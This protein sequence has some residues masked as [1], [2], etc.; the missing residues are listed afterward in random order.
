DGGASTAREA[1]S[2]STPPFVDVTAASQIAYR[3]GYTLPSYIRRDLKGLL[4]WQVLYMTIGGAAAGDC[5]GDGDID[6]F[7]TYGNT[8]GADGGGGP[9]RLYLNQLVEQ[10]NGLLFEDRAAFAGVAN[11]R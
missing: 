4:T 5:D 7:I 6:L 1:A 8:G 10:D 9:N 3:V 2:P 11:T